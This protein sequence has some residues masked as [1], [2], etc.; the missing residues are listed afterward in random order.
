MYFLLCLE[1]PD[2][3]SPTGYYA[4]AFDEALSEEGAARCLTHTPSYVLEALERGERKIIGVRRDGEYGECVAAYVLHDGSLKALAEDNVAFDKNLLSVYFDRYI[5]EWPSSWWLDQRHPMILLKMW[6]I[7]SHR[8]DRYDDSIFSRG[9]EI[10]LSMDPST[11]DKVVIENVLYSKKLRS[12]MY[13]DIYGMQ[14][15]YAMDTSGYY[16]SEAL[17]IALKKGHI[18]DFLRALIRSITPIHTSPD[19]ENLAEVELDKLIPLANV[20]RQSIPYVDVMV[21]VNGYIP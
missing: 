20:I 5:E 9:L 16:A 4:V 19:I 8:S 15:Q 6:E 11:R 13:R 17:M 3:D 10:L 7:V 12:D 14:N 21:R 1:T 18:D 2:I